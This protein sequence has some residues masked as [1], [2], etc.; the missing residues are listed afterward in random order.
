MHSEFEA[1]LAMNTD[2][3]DEP[4]TIIHPREWDL[5]PIQDDLPPSWRKPWTA[6]R[7][8]VRPEFPWALLWAAVI[9]ADLA[10]IAWE[11]LA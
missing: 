5:V 2:F 3:H 11:L 7:R 10:V 8:I 1:N 4:D 9:A 6:P